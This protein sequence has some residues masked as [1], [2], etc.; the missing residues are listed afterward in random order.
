MARPFLKRSAWILAFL[1]GGT[2]LVSAAGWLLGFPL[3]RQLFYGLALGAAVFL[4][5]WLLWKG[6][7][8]FLW[9]V[10]R[11]LAFSY[12]LIGALPIP[13]VVLLILLNLYLL[14]GYFLGH[15][16]RDAAGNLQ[17]EVVDA[18][19]TQLEKRKWVEHRTPQLVDCPFAYYLDGQRTS[20]SADLPEYWPDWL[21]D[22]PDPTTEKKPVIS[23]VARADGT[24]TLA[25]TA[26]GDRH[27]V[28][29]VFDGPVEAELARRSQV[30]VMLSAS[31]GPPKGGLDPSRLD[32]QGDRPATIGNS[33]GRPG[34]GSVLRLPTRRVRRIP[35]G[36]DRSSGG[37]SWPVPSRACTTVRPSPST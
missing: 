19:V 4:V 23:F 8:M 5:L 28:L 9:R 13:M 24:P 21:A 16:Y 25:A 18:A 1:A 12:F 34:A 26:A 20:G 36:G 15:L 35:G 27:G 30:W 10:G 22:R 31:R 32:G 17:Q 6:L 3:T 29:A 11:R 7:Q 37:V 33:T 14:S 2:L